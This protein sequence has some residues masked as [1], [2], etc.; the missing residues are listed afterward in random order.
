[1]ISG[2]FH[3]TGTYTCKPPM[4]EHGP[5]YTDE[6]FV[7]IEFLDYLKAEINK[8]SVRLF[9]PAI[10]RLPWEPVTIQGIKQKIL[11]LDPVTGSNTGLLL[12]EAGVKVDTL[13]NEYEQEMMILKGS[14]KMGDKIYPAGS[15][16]CLPPGI[17][18]QP[19]YTNEQLLA[20]RVC[21]VW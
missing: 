17:E 10:R 6:G 8:P 7:E 11:A 15:Y 18:R 12:I 21:T 4:T 20:L 14:C 16:L 13:S 3:P 9:P 19:F 2:E 1:M 5:C